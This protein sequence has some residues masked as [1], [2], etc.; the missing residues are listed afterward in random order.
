[1]GR[2]CGR[3]PPPTPPTQRASGRLAGQSS[4][5][6]HLLAGSRRRQGRAAA[7]RCRRARGAPRRAALR[8]RARAVVLMPTARSFFRGHF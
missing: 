8:A 6:P 7:A 3:A 5:L 2:A 4:S 1:M